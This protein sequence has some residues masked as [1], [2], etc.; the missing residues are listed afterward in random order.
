MGGAAFIESVHRATA[1]DPVHGQSSPSSLVAV[2]LPARAVS[3]LRR[4]A[5]AASV[6]KAINV[7]PGAPGAHMPYSV[8]ELIRDV[9]IAYLR[10]A[11]ELGD[12]P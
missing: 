3:A 11:D 2:K 6:V 12:S 5:Q 1:C 9:I 8:E 7:G 4:R 10:E